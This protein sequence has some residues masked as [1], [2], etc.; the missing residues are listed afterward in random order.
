MIQ[1]PIDL[2]RL[3]V[4]AEEVSKDSLAPHPEYFLRETSIA[5]SQTLSVA[6]VS[7]LALSSV[8]LANSG[9]RVHGDG[10][11]NDEAVRNEL[12]DILSYG[13]GAK[14]DVR[15]GS[16]WRWA[17]V[18]M[19]VRRTNLLELATAISWIS[20]GSSHTLFFPQRRTEAASLFCNLSDTM[21]ATVCYKIRECG[22]GSGRSLGAM[23]IVDDTL[24]SAVQ[25]RD[26][27]PS[28]VGAD[29]DEQSVSTIPTCHLSLYATWNS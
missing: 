8:Q 6:A 12:S 13:G 15:V 25:S 2:L 14:S 4:L 26:G 16:Y 28:G 22:R 23:N 27:A 11:L 9:A 1:I 21:A 3:A 7:A 29:V 24:H 5:G 19:D 10:L 18:T 17:V 20:L